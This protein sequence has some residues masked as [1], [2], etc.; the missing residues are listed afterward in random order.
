MPPEEARKDFLERLK[1]YERAYEA[2]DDTKDADLPYIQVHK[3]SDPAFNLD[4]DVYLIIS[5]LMSANESLRTILMAI[6]LAKLCSI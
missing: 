2:L 4:S 6:C 3:K 1:N 5:L